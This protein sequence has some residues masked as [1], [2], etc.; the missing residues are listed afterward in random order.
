[1]INNWYRR[2]GKRLVDLI[3]AGMLLLL[4]FP[5]IVMTAVLVRC[6]LGRPVLFRQ[7]RP[8]RYEKTFAIV[9]FRTMKAPYASDNRVLP[10]TERLTRVGRILRKASLDELPQLWNVVK[11]DMSLVG[12]RPLLTHY[13]GYYSERERLRHSVRPGITGLA[14][15][16]G[17]NQRSWDERLELDARYAERVSPSL[18]F[19]IL[20]ITIWKVLAMSDNVAVPDTVLQPLSNVRGSRSDNATERCAK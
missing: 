17:R 5:L 9:K 2:S 18:D 15:I 8:G 16:C 13:L 1:M 6:S 19:R 3:I 11:G 4:F 12:P 14:Q 20:V 7:K 10:E